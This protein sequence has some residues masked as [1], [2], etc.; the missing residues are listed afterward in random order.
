MKAKLVFKSVLLVFLCFFLLTAGNPD[1]AYAIKFFEGKVD[2]SGFIRNDSAWRVRDGA[3]SSPQA[4][5]DAGD[6]I[7]C[8]N[9]FQL[10]I[11]YNVNDWLSLFVMPS[12]SMK[13]V[14]TLTT[15]CGIDSWISR[16]AIIYTIRP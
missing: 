7:L 8:R 16:N 13:R 2:V 11:L 15:T 12:L 14:W 1:E 9:T 6:Y 3:R 10:E 5:L 4:G